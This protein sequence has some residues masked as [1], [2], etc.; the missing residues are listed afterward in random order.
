[1]DWYA[2]IKLAHIICAVVW[3]GGGFALMLA[4]IRADNAGDIAGTLQVMRTIGQLG[5]RLFM[6]TSMLTLL[7]GLIMCWFWVGFGDLWIVLALIGFAVSAGIGSAVFKP[8]AD[9]MNASIAKDGV[10]P[11]V[12]DEG[13][14][15][16]RIARL[17]YTIMLLVVVDMVLKPTGDDFALLAVMGLLLVAGIVAAFG[18]G[19]RSAAAQA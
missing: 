4:A 7:F 12:M 8:T 14:K 11:A 16:L 18:T 2:L 13:R 15:I 10:T 5:N 9:R 6:P 17:D 3:V 19:A 1:M